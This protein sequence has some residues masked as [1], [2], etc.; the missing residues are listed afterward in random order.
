MPEN[1]STHICKS[2]GNSFI[3]LY[4]NQCG[5]KVLEKSDFSFRA[6]LSQF[7]LI[8]TFADNKFIR[9]LKYIILRPGFMSSEYAEG[10]RVNYMRPLQ[11]FFILN[12]IYFL[13]PL[14]QLFNTSLN[15][16]MHLRTHSPLV[17]EMVQNHLKKEHLSYEGFSLMYNERSTS[18]AKLILVVFVVIASIPMAVIFMKSKRMF[19]EHV[20]FAVELVS[21]NLAINAIA[22][23]V[24]LIG[25]NK[26]L[27]WTH[28]GWERYLDDFTL[29]IIFVLT[30]LYF[31][32]SASRLYYHQK[33][34]ALVVK[35]VLA[36][37][38]LFVSL[39]IYRL[40]LFLLT[41]WLV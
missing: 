32:F 15:T 7:V 41:F 13:F 8:V 2:C 34:F 23:S 25:I 17:K 33:N 12:L 31:L 1:T 9:T 3:G 40:I 28:S 22:L 26:I 37:I 39:E 14:L 27:H 21:F 4:C 16:Q 11:M 29:T 6:L 18:L 20:T 36:M 30:N 35:V 5:E 19:T 24:I 38:S 10:R